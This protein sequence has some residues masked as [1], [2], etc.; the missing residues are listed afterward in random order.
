MSTT[1]S[2]FTYLCLSNSCRIFVRSSATG[3]L[4]MYIVWISGAYFTRTS[5][6]QPNENWAQMY[7]AARIMEVTH[8]SKP[9]PVGCYYTVLC[10][11]PRGSWTSLTDASETTQ[12]DKQV[13]VVCA[14]YV[15]LITILAKCVGA[16]NG[17][18][19]A[20][21]WDAALKHRGSLIAATLANWIAPR[22]GMA[23]TRYLPQAGTGTLFS[24]VCLATALRQLL[25]S[26]R[27]TS[28]LALHL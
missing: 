23:S 15:G 20:L 21:G 1:G 3:L 6:Y 9:F 11:L 22:L 10:N 19:S 12:G 26:L 14:R 13:R 18:M 25:F 16:S 5:G 8:C 4:S 17:N 2:C 7:I 24:H 28:P 27:A